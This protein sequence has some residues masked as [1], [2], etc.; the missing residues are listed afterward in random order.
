MLKQSGCLAL[1]WIL[2]HTDMQDGPF[3]HFQH[4]MPACALFYGYG[5]LIRSALT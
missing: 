3:H 4:I 2:P 1:D 5:Y